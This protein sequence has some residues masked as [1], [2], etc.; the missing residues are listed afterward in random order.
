[1]ADFPDFTAAGGKLNI[2]NNWIWRT[3]GGLIHR[4]NDLPALISKNC[5]VRSWYINDQRHRDHAPA[6]IVRPCFDREGGYEEW[7]FHGKLHRLDGPA[8][9]HYDDGE[10]V[11]YVDGVY[12]EN[13]DDDAYKEACRRFRIEHGLLESG[14][15]TKRAPL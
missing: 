4:D 5:A 11:Y 3:K 9:R 1:M 14:K 10:V 2:Y 12:F 15:L 7:Y 8:I 6:H 13:G